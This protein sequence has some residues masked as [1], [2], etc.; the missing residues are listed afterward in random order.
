MPVES[1]MEETTEVEIEDTKGL[2]DNVEKLKEKFSE[3]SEQEKLSFIS[4]L[5]S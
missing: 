2:M 5:L 1:D 3:L 4:Q